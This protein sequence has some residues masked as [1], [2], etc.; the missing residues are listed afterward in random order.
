M[1]EEYVPISEEEL[2][3]RSLRQTA[4]S[5]HMF[6]AAMRETERRMTMTERETEET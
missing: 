6:K 4:L 2:E 3:T 1:R 5:P